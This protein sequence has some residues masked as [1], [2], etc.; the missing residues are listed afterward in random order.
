[1]FKL[2][3]WQQAPPSTSVILPRPLQCAYLH[4]AMVLLGVAIL[5]S[6]FC[7]TNKMPSQCGLVSIDA[8]QVNVVS[9]AWPHVLA[10][11]LMA[12]LSQKCRLV[13]FTAD[14]ASHT[15]RIQLQTV[16]CPRICMTSSI[17]NVL[18]VSTPANN[19]RLH[20]WYT[21]VVTI[22]WHCPPPKPIPWMPFFTTGLIWWVGT[23]LWA[24]VKSHRLEYTNFSM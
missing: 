12:I 3:P 13:F 8:P 20:T 22:P 7:N 6:T 10:D 14:N 15:N 2:S 23:I 17:A 24:S 18:T 11:M 16:L 5:P 9:C 21:W 1:M 4:L 19:V